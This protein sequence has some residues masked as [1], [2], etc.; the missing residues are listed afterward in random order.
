M[1]KFR[2]II[3]LIIVLAG[4]FAMPAPVQAQDYLFE[5]TAQE[6]E[7]YIEED[8]TL[9]LWYLIEF[10]NAPNGAPIEFVD[11]GMPSSSY[12]LKSIEATLDGKPKSRRLKAPPM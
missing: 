9:S 5:V 2:S 1:K 7:A 12:S 11:I 3:L 6:V 4:L 8:G 10:Q